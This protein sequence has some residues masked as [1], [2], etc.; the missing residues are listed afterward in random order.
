M[1]GRRSYERVAV[2]SGGE[3]VLRVARDIGLRSI[4]DREIVAISREA[5]VVG[6][7]VAVDLPEDGIH[8]QGVLVESRLVVQEGAVRHRLRLRVEAGRRA[9]VPGATKLS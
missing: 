9:V 7:T 2:M 4:D 3:G 6:E 5:G 8:V 1:L